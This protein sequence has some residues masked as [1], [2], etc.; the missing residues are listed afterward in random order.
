LSISVAP[1]LH[2][3]GYEAPR[4]AGTVRGRHVP[5]EVRYAVWARD[6]WICAY[7]GRECKRE[8]P[9]NG[10]PGHNDP[11]YATCDHLVP[12]SEG[13]RDIPPN[14]VTACLGC[15]SRKGPKPL[16]EF[17]ATLEA[18]G[19]DRA[20]IEA[21]I[22]RAAVETPAAGPVSPSVRPAP[23]D[24]DVRARSAADAPE[25]YEHAYQFATGV[26]PASAGVRAKM[27]M[28]C[29]GVGG[30]VPP[31]PRAPET[32]PPKIS[33]V[34]APRETFDEQEEVL[35]RIWHGEDE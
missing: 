21:R 30:L 3:F 23:E 11:G 8:R 24:A 1:A 7:C 20:A 26:I 35:R 27:I 12:H 4:P 19:A 33:L 31:K 9:G 17:L 13:G 22:A 16:S 2:A 5:D 15:N 28:W 25:L 14:M 6:E 10:L 32:A 18:E 34:D 29:A